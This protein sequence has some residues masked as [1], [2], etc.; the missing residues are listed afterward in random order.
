MGYAELLAQGY[1][2]R[3]DARYGSRTGLTTLH[4]AL[5]N[6]TVQPCNILVMGAS[7]VEG[8]GAGSF[9]GRYVNRLQALLRAKY[10]GGIA[11]GQFYSAQYLSA[12][13][14]ATPWTYTGGK[15]N[16]GTGPAGKSIIL[17]AGRKASISVTGTSVDILYGKNPTSG[18]IGWALD[19]GAVTNIVATDA[20]T[21]DMQKTNIPLTGGAHTLD[22]SGVAGNT[23]F[24]G[25]RLYN[26]DEA[27]GVSV[28]DSASGALGSDFQASLANVSGWRCLRDLAACYPLH[29]VVILD[30]PLDDYYHNIPVSNTLA[31]LD[32][33]FTELS[34]GAS[35]YS[36]LVGIPI[37]GLGSENFAPYQNALRSYAGASDWFDESLRV[38]DFLLND[39]APSAYYDQLHFNAKGNALMGY[40][41]FSALDIK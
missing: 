37:R 9:A 3:L 27:A 2:G 21:T 36:K 39:V 20:A 15:I 14:W 10:N 33:I 40:S 34:V 25:I 18:T 23:I 31:N 13:S 24:D 41:L 1:D 28:I 19:G 22:I 17:A 7:R 6:A 5:A 30:L 29:A 38:P 12:I 11:G 26:G 4:A 16:A 32:T 8:Y 35:G